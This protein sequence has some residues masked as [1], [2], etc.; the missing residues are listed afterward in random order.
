M[1]LTRSEYRK[2]GLEIVSI[3]DNRSHTPK[4]PSVNSQSKTVFSVELCRGYPKLLVACSTSF[5]FL[6]FNKILDTWFIQ[7][8]QK[9]DFRWFGRAPGVL[10]NHRKRSISSANGRFELQSNRRKGLDEQKE[11]SCFRTSHVSNAAMIEVSNRRL[12]RHDDRSW[13]RPKG[14]RFRRFILSTSSPNR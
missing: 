13:Y 1:S 14:S 6:Y 7:R 12:A 4:K 10:I 11:S 2:L 5:L 9:G 3:E 8:V